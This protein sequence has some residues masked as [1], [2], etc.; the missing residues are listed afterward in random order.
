MQFVQLCV[1]SSHRKTFNINKSEERQI[2][3]IERVRK[4]NFT[5]TNNTKG[6]NNN[7]NENNNNQASVHMLLKEGRTEMYGER[8][9]VRK[10]LT[11]AN[12]PLY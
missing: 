11:N 1:F 4:K 8:E 7:H 10:K 12:K 5:V 2:D 3:D 6:I 9:R